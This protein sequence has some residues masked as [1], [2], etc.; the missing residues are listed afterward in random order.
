[1]LRQSRKFQ[2]STAL[3]LNY[4]SSPALTQHNLLLRVGAPVPLGRQAIALLRTLVD[5]P[6]A[7]VSLAS[8]NSEMVDDGLGVRLRKRGSALSN[9][10]L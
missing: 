9:K 2:P 5:Q 6:G 10:E 1:M 7:L 3:R 8:C 4:G